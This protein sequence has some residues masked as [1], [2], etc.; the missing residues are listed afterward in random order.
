MSG[1]D[2]GPTGKEKSRPDGEEAAFSKVHTTES[3]VAPT[4]DTSS[5]ARA[6][7]RAR[8]QASGR[9]PFCPPTSWAADARAA[10][11]KFGLSAGW[12]R[13]REARREYGRSGRRGRPPEPITLPRDFGELAAAVRV[14]KRYEFNENDLA[15]LLAGAA[16]FGPPTRDAGPVISQFPN[17]SER[18]TS[19]VSELL[20][21]G[22]R[23]RITRRGRQ[24]RRRSHP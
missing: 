14:A 5:A 2:R 18:R 4:Q 17:R 9:R 19:D 6:A 8:L 21:S 15:V 20:E 22:G 12:A 1:A 10:E 11:F 13:M 16:D 3:S 24:H 7:E 23:R